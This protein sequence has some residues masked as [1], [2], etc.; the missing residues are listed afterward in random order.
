VNLLLPLTTQVLPARRSRP[1]LPCHCGGKCSLSLL[2]TCDGLGF[3]CGPYLARVPNKVKPGWPVGE[4]LGTR[5]RGRA[6]W[7]GKSQRRNGRLSQVSGIGHLNAVRPR[8][9][10]WRAVWCQGGGFGGRL[11]PWSCPAASWGAPWSLRLPLRL[12]HIAG[13]AALVEF[14]DVEDCL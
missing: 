13:V 5:W 1:S 9:L 10:G 12:P 7:C 6:V 3:S 4:A 14:F 11:C 8:F 2:R